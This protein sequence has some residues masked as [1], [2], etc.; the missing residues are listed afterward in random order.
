MKSK[1]RWAVIFQ[2]LQ[3]QR[4]QGLAT[5]RAVFIC[6]GLILTLAAG[7]QGG[8]SPQVQI[9]TG[10]LYPGER[11]V[12]HLPDLKRGDTLYIY[13]QRLSG[14]LDPLFAV[15]DGQ[16]QMKMFDEQLNAKLQK[17]PHSPYSVF[18]DLLE[19][20]YLAWDDDSGQGSDAA[21]KFSIPADGNYKIVVAGSRQPVGRQVTGQ[22]FGAYRLLIGVN[23]PQVLTGQATSTGAVLA[24]LEVAPSA[25]VRIQE[26]T[27]TLTR[28]NNATYFR[29]ADLDPGATLYV[30][31]E[32][33]SADLR[34]ALTLRN[35]SNKV[36]R[37]DNW[38]QQR[39]VARLQHTFK[40]LAHN[41]SL[42]VAGSVEQGQA[43]S[44]S[45]RVLLGTNAPEILEGQGR[46]AGRPLIREPIQV[47]VGIRLD[48]ITEVNQRGE[49]FGVVG[50]LSL[51][52][53]DPAFAFNPDSC[54]CAVKVMDSALFEKFVA[55][56]YL[57]W[58]R[59][60]FYNQQGKRWTQGEV[61][62]IYPNGKVTYYERFSATLQAPDFN[63]QRFPLDTQ[64]FFIR[65]QCL[66]P[67]EDYQ[68]VNIPGLTSIGQQLGEEEWYITNHDTG[69]TSVIISE[70][71]AASR[72]SFRFF[73]KRHLSYYIFRIFVPLLLIIAVSWV[74][75]FLQD[76]A[77]RVDISGA[78]LLV[79]IAFNFTIG[80][81]L[82]RLGY[83]TLLDTMLIVAFV[84]TTLTVICNVALKR[85]DA[86]GKT[87]I[88]KKIDTYI[89]W[90]YPIFYVA[91]FILL[92]LVFFL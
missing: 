65:L 67:E 13:M 29:L 82:P 10:Y 1:N 74:T 26:I 86:A 76:Y 18:R 11:E 43:T 75:F 59:F 49:N 83:L 25:R 69:V 44:G 88:T 78:N 48:Q 37:V 9:T 81:D 21:L 57:R 7:G 50:D 72:F 62:R 47:R 3:R 71:T 73:C 42:E 54:Q 52:W 38:Q 51:E 6:I 79:F 23:A 4:H 89:L 36:L 2:V 14:N 27:G 85:L 32:A 90:G 58:P 5:A 31:V 28:E 84:V 55:E 39:H 15:A 80:S 46:P 19:T 68:F 66:N 60:I 53:V 12:Y 87:E 40:E 16:F 45:F 91:G 35:Y 8:A 24:R 77:K 34:P 92:A 64:Q 30:R 70:D 63:F 33:T 61:F 22:T 41:W 17:T 20:F 56:N